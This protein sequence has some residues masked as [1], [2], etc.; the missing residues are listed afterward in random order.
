[1]G[2]K[3]NPKGFNQLTDDK[4]ILVVNRATGK[5]TKLIPLSLNNAT[6]ERLK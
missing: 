6:Y 1:M 5:I 4:N 2:K 3:K